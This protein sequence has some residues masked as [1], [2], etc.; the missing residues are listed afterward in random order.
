MK[1]GKNTEKEEK[2]IE[3][4]KVRPGELFVVAGS[5]G[6]I[7]I[8][9]LLAEKPDWFS[10]WFSASYLERILQEEEPYLFDEE[11]P[12]KE[13]V[14]RFG[15][16]GWRAVGEGGILKAVWDFSGEQGIGLTFGL[17]RIPVKQ[18]VIELCEQCGANPYAIWCG[19]CLLLA[20][21]EGWQ[22]VQN[23]REQ[24]MEAEVIGATEAGIARRICHGED[25]TGYLER[26]REDELYRLLG[27]DGLKLADQ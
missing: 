13:L 16:T 3:N 8:R 26:P 7:G 11:K 1:T 2:I 9:T 25:G 10:P 19:R 4:R 12:L 21:K 27:R 20:V 23:L 17:R 6:Q 5:I 14:D 18:H 24:G 22:L 15:I